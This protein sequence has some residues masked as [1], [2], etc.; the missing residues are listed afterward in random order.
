MVPYYHSLFSEISQKS[1]DAT[2][3]VLGIRNPQLRNHIKEQLTDELDRGNR[4]LADPVF[5]AAFP[6]ETASCVHAPV[7]QC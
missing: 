5:E 7:R 2:L 3:G 6:E 1:V 4:I